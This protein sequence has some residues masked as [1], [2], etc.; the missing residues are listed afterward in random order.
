MP[1]Y[2]ETLGIDPG[3]TAAEIE[4]AYRFLAQKFHPD[5]NPTNPDLARQRFQVVQ[6]A[7][8]TLS[9]PKHRREYDLKIGVGLNHDWD[10]V[11]MNVDRNGIKFNSDGSLNVGGTYIKPD[12]G[13]PKSTIG[14]ATIE[15]DAGPSGE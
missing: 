6:Q 7:F 2:Y 5:A 9:D 15:K 10:P 14:A 4:K 11:P 3:A 12:E 13:V 1:S 8:E